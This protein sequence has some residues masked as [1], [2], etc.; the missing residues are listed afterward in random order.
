MEN[1]TE[2]SFEAWKQRPVYVA[3]CRTWAL[4]LKLN[5]A[6][7]RFRCVPA[8]RDDQALTARKAVADVIRDQRKVLT[9]KRAVIS[10]LA[11]VGQHNPKTGFLVDIQATIDLHAELHQLQR[12]ESTFQ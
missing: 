2:G 4:A 10:Q 9:R 12:E 5:L 3:Q 6:H 7:H 1:S 11:I 8:Y